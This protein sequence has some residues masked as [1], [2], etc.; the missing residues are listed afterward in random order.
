L[1]IGSNAARGSEE[2]EGQHSPSH[3]ET[4]SPSFEQGKHRFHDLH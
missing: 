1:F 2:L 3:I 4:N